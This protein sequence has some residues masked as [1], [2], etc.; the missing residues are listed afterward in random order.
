MNPY[1]WGG[2]SGYDFATWLQDVLEWMKMPETKTFYH[3]LGL[4]SYFTGY[5][6]DWA[7]EQ[8]EQYEIFTVDGGYQ[9]FPLDEWDIQVTFTRKV[10]PI[11]VNTWVTLHTSGADETVYIKAVVGSYA[12]VIDDDD[13]YA[14][15]WIEKLDRLSAS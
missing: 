2:E 9:Q 12:W 13:P 11:E 1:S 10:K 15:G 7:E 14:T 8:S 5:K 4:S 6:H 3:P